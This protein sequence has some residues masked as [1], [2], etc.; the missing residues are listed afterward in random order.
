MTIRVR[1]VTI[2]DLSILQKMSIETF[3]YAFKAQNTSENLNLYL[4]KAFDINKLRNEI[5]NS[6][7]FFCYQF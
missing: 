5:L 2:K 1:K 6:S 3:T 7:S 4:E